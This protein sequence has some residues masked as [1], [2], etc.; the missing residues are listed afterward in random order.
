L[1]S[2]F[3]DPSKKLHWRFVKEVDRPRI[4]HARVA[5]VF[6]NDNLYAQVTVRMHTEQVRNHV[7][8][9]STIYLKFIF[10]LVLFL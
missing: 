10:S 7:L 6:D 3:Q 9:K 8:F 1:K 5:S 2:Q 4:V